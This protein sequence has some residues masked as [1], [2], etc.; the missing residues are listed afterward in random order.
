[1]KQEQSRNPPNCSTLPSYKQ[2]T[3]GN[4]G[5]LRACHFFAT[6]TEKNAGKRRSASHLL[7]F[8]DQLALNLVFPTV[9]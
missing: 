1:M 6:F 9:L 7:S 4:E 3:S 2:R 5:S 8:L